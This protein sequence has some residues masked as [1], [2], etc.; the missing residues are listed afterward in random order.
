MKTLKQLRNAPILEQFSGAFNYY[1]V[2]ALELELQRVTNLINRA[3]KRNKSDEFIG[4]LQDKEDDLNS[5]LNNLQK[6]INADEDE[7]QIYKNSR[8]DY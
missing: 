5:E 6:I 4:A 7:I 8:E 2:D 1:L 3:I